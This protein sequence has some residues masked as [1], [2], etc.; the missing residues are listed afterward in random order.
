MMQ[1]DANTLT[2]EEL[3]AEVKGLEAQAFALINDDSRQD[4]FDAVIDRTQLL[5]GV[6]MRKGWM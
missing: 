1:R 6:A 4:E 2:K 5:T 3:V